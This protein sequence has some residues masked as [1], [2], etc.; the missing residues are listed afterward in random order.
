MDVLAFLRL[1]LLLLL[2]QELCLRQ[3]ELS[4]PDTFNKYCDVVLFVEGTE[5]VSCPCKEQSQSDMPVIVP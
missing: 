4:L 2:W 3:L 5:A 1:W